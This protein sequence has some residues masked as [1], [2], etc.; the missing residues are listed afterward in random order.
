MRRM[1]KQSTLSLHVQGL[2]LQALPAHRQ[3]SKVSEVLRSP[4][5]RGGVLRMPNVAVD[6]ATTKP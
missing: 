4:R 3:V 6:L 2:R 1:T 5:P